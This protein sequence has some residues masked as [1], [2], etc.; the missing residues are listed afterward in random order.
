VAGIEEMNKKKPVNKGKPWSDAQLR[1]I[2]RKAPTR[3][4]L[5]L[6]ANRFGRTE[7][8]I[9]Q[10]Y[11]F[12]LLRRLVGTGDAFAA[13]VAK[14]AREVEWITRDSAAAQYP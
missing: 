12:A 6:L 11:H 4:N 9:R 8:S 13:Q 14:V 1:T 3:P 7:N 5:K 2:L 10:I